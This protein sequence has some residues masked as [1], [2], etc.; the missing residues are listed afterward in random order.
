MGKSV[1][2]GDMVM[3]LV[4]DGEVCWTRQVEILFT[5]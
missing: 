4:V 3:A 1:G 2:S 5:V